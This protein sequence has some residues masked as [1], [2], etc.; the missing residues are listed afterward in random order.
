MVYFTSDLH[1]GHKS[2]VH[3]CSRPFDSVEEMDAGLIKNWNDT[4]T[5][6]DTIYVLGDVC[7][8]KPILG[9]PL[10]QSLKGKKILIQGNHDRWS[11]SKYLEA[12][13]LQIL[14]EAKLIL[15]GFG[16]KLSHYPYLP[17]ELVGCAPH[18]LRYPEMRPVN[19]GGWLLCGHVHLNWKIMGN[20]INVG[21]DKWDFK[22]V[23]QSQI[24]SLVMKKA[25]S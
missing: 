12:G 14:Q 11:K 5:E 13:F 17:N 4:V 24:L 9:L 15:N 2:V 23:S 25:A 8:H 10:L 22:P 19:E 20:Q 18:D 16:F 1:L 7:F 3:F 6:E 21:V